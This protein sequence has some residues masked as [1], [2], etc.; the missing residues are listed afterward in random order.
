MCNSSPEGWLFVM[1]CGQIGSLDIQ[2]VV[3]PIQTH[4]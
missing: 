1:S 4:V 3:H 2:A